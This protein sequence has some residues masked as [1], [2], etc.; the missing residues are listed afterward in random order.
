[1]VLLADFVEWLFTDRHIV[2]RDLDYVT[3]RIG[4][5]HTEKLILEFV[6]SRH[7]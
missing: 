5:V 6:A 4:S 3:D 7:D 2:L 1:M